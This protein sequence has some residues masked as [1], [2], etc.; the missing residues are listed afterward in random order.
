MLAHFLGLLI[1]LAIRGVRDLWRPDRSEAY[2]TRLR[3]GLPW[4]GEGGV[5]A[6]AAAVPAVIGAASGLVIAAIAGFLTD[7]MAESGSQLARAI[8]SVVFLLGFALFV[9]GT[10]LAACA[11]ILRRPAMVV[12]PAIRTRR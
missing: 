10:I 4:L 5:L 6:L 8:G 3:R 7:S 11:A 1:F 9:G 2:L 12:P